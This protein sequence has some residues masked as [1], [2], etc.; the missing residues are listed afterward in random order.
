MHILRLTKGVSSTVVALFLSLVVFSQ[1]AVA[2]NL[3]RIE[4]EYKLTVPN[5]IADKVWTYLNERYEDGDALFLKQYDPRF[6]T[7][8][9]TE[10]FVDEYYD[11]PD[12]K[13]LNAQSA[14]R[15][16][17][18]FIPDDTGHRKHGRQMVQIKLN[19]IDDNALNRGEIKF[20]VLP[21]A[22]KRYLLLHLVSASE[23]EL[24]KN[25]MNGIGV[26]PE[27]LR[28]MLLLTQERKR[29][30]ISIADT[31]FATITL[32][33]VSS[34]KWWSKVDFFEIEMELNEIAYTDS[35]RET[36]Q[37]MEAINDELMND[38]L[39]NFPAIKQDQTP[40]YNKTFSVFNQRFTLFSRALRLNA[41]VEVVA[42]MSVFLVLLLVAVLVA[43]RRQNLI[44]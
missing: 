42:A 6:N 21:S 27:K 12:L 23:R 44:R 35:D 7:S 16:R 17:K 19:S 24:F 32:D 40:K 14:V 38:L 9:S 5:D 34:Q 41:P 31:P 20:E 10:Y 30:Y 18:R 29:V 36:R 15:H 11:T 26:N 3:M 33:H 22:N 28:P 4:N 2:Q 8:F 37:Q 25:A 43:T 1:L 13:L 39:K